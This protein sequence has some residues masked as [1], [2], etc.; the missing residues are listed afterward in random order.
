MYDGAKVVRG[1]RV[2][3]KTERP[4]NSEALTLWAVVLCIVTVAGC[5]D[6]H[7]ASGHSGPPAVYM[8]ERIRT[9]VGPSTDLGRVVMLPAKGG[10]VMSWAPLCQ[11]DPVWRP[12]VF[13]PWCEH[14]KRTVGHVSA[15]TVAAIRKLAHRLH[16]DSM[17][18]GFLDPRE[19]SGESS[20]KIGAHV[21]DFD[22][23]CPMAGILGFRH[24]EVHRTPYR[25][26][27]ARFTRL[28][29]AIWLAW[30]RSS[31]SVFSRVPTM[32]KRCMR[33]VSHRK[34]H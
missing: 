24:G 19:W 13:K 27:G 9:E 7:G 18:H 8:Y 11:V 33:Y 23:Y 1:D 25:G 12:F 5:A 21:V 14:K 32:Q 20:I 34:P 17:P 29:R 31:P 15:A 10:S 2:E 30:E 4:S 28:D 16:F 22:D 6:R 26:L 3:G